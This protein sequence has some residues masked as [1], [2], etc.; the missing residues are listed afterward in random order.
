MVSRAVR[1]RGAEG[2]G[3]G[4]GGGGTGQIRLWAPPCAR[5][6]GSGAGSRRRP[7]RGGSPRRRARRTRLS[8]PR[9][10]CRA[11]IVGSTHGHDTREERNEGSD[12]REEVDTEDREPAVDL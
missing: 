12:K 11:R 7:C 4:L 8:G 1:P 3:G 9:A 2:I 6:A 5:S 10:R